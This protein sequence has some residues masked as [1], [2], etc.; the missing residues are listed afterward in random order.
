VEQGKVAGVVTP[1]N[2]A[3]VCLF[4]GHVVRLT[5]GRWNLRRLLV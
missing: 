3:V 2:E 4:R 1:F 5:P